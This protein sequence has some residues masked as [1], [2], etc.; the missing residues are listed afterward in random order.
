M[1][2]DAQLISPSSREGPFDSAPV[3]DPVVADPA[4]HG[5]IVA[6]TFVLG[7][8]SVRLIEALR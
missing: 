6:S 2:V 4:P 5:S 3:T 1:A 8:E 7:A